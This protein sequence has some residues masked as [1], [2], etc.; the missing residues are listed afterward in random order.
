MNSK[1]FG[2]AQG[3]TLLEVMIALTIFVAIALTLSQTASQSVDSI[4]YM[5]DKT[6]ASM[7][8]ENQLNEIRLKGLPR[9]G[10][11]KDQVRFASR[12]WQIF[13]QVEK[14]EFP[15]TFRITL[16]VADMAHKD[17]NLATLATIMGKH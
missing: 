15:D 14:T 5:Q 16:S 11:K 12:E 9:A 13:T 1:V 17:S 6:L 3:F 4:L 8:A 7:L 10:E 2:K